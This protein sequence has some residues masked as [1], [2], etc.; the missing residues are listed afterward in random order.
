MYDTKHIGIV[1]GASGT[2]VI[3]C[4]IWIQRTAWRLHRNLTI[5]KNSKVPLSSHTHQL[6]WNLEWLQKENSHANKNASSYVLHFHVFYSIFLS[7]F[8]L[9]SYAGECAIA[10]IFT[11]FLPF[12]LF[13][14]GFCEILITF[15]DF[16]N[17]WILLF[18]S[19]IIFFEE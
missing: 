7:S 17:V 9:F 12:F 13:L 1:L 15:M 11:C 18:K 19:V 3:I 4:S 10:G 14:L 6:G 5:H 8:F 16:W 2:F